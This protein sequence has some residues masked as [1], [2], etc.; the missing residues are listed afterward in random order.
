MNDSIAMTELADSPAQHDYSPSTVA[1]T[2]CIGAGG[3]LILGIQPV[4]MAGLIETGVLNDTSL[5]WSATTEILSVTLGVYLGPRWLVTQKPRF[6]IIVAALWMT[7]ANLATPIA[8]HTASV[9][10]IRGAAGLAEGFL[11]A[12][13]V[14]V[15]TYSRSPARISAIFLTVGAVPQG[16][17][18]YILPGWLSP[19][20][21][22][23]AG[24]IV[25]G[26]IGFA[27]AVLTIGVRD[28][29]VP[30][31]VTEVGKLSGS[32]VVLFSLAATLMTACGIGACW[33]YADRVGAEIGLSADQVGVCFT[34]SLIFQMLAG[35]VIAVVGWRLSFK[36]ALLGGA[37]LQI[38]AVLGLLASRGFVGMLSSLGLFGLLWQ[39]CLPFASDLMVSVDTSR[40]SA[41][42]VLPLAC[43]GL[44]VGPFV[45]S[46]FVASGARGALEVGLWI[47][48]A[49][50]LSYGIL[51]WRM[52]RYARRAGG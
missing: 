32:P 31:G 47:F 22:P 19:H 23:D 13:A 11:V 46:F 36:S 48:V 12:V 20:F 27:C 37:L 21:G 6:V 28:P 43:L 14:L 30:G 39:G 52:S 10:W 44:S 50:A 51:F 29:L 4:L 2:L 7:L 17:M 40:K 35:L 38:V 42:L 3:L 1:S 15:V 18:T 24:F 5:G 45:A 9:L 8:S 41:P 16:L 25:M 34:A 26:M 33:S 49:A